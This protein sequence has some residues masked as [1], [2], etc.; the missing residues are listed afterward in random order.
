MSLA[1]G[2]AFA[3]VPSWR[4]S[5][6]P[7]TISTDTGTFGLFLLRLPTRN[8]GYARSGRACHSK[9]GCRDTE[10]SASKGCRRCSRQLC[11]GWLL[12]SSQC[13]DGQRQSCEPGGLVEADRQPEIG[14][15][16]V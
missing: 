10:G 15:A 13:P 7:P 14:R 12:A 11:G 16:H 8:S 2:V 1:A 5:H 3:V 6:E 4:S 9:G